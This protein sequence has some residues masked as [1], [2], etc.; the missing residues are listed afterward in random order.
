MLNALQS[1]EAT[2][3]FVDPIRLAMDNED[4]QTGI[5]IELCVTSYSIRTVPDT[6]IALLENP[7]DSL[8]SARVPDHF[9]A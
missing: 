3:K 7:D 5:V 4:F 6:R 8:G 9:A 2:R 1:D